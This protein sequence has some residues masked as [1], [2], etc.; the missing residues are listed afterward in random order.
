VILLTGVGDKEIDFEATKAGATDY[1]LKGEINATVLE[2]AIRYAIAAKRQEEQR[3]QLALAR[4][5][6]A[7]AEAANRAK[8]EFLAMV[9]HELRAPLNAMLVWLGVLKEPKIDPATA[10]K[11]LATVERNAQQ[12]ARILDDLLDMTR[13]MHGMLRIEK[14]PVQL[15]AVVEAAV[16]GVRP[17]AEAKSIAIAVTRGPTLDPIAADPGRLQQIVVNLLS[18]S[19][20][21]TPTEGRI[22]VGLASI[23]G[24]AGPHAQ[25]TVVDTGVGISS[26]ALPYVFDR[27]RQAHGSYP[28]SQTGLGLGLAIVRSLVELHGGS[29]Q[30]ESPGEGLG[31]TFTVRLPFASVGGGR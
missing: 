29:V 18:N 20:K 16:A 27:Y 31:A 21:F 4:V 17:A 14:R 12:Q 5:A 3:F 25:I 9:S 22:A 28:G 26:S 24:P 7:Q 23:Q 11:A 2:R 15:A 1:L 19:V 8:D 10:A 13:I 30:A 6:E